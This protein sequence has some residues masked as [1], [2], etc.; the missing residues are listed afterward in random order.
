MNIDV[1]IQDRQVQAALNRAL[2]AVGNP[3][4]LMRTLANQQ[5]R[6]TVEN[7]QS[8]EFNGQPWP[9]LSPETAQRFITGTPGSRSGRGRRRDRGHRRGYD[10]M[11]RPTGLHIFQRLFQRHTSHTAEVWCDN[12]WAFVHN[13]GAQLRRFKMP[14]RQFL[15]FSR[16]DLESIVRACKWWIQRSVLP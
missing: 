10:N 1:R 16:E 4:S 7:F 6:S 3:S 5:Y 15:G 9:E 14:Q 11:L 13:F 8:E 12:P 2:R